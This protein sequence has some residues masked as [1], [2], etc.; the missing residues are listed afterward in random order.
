MPLFLPTHPESPAKKGGTHRSGRRQRRSCRSLSSRP[1]PP[2]RFGSPVRKPLPGGNSET[3][4]C[5]KHPQPAAGD[6]PPASGSPNDGIRENI[7][8][9]PLKNTLTFPS[10]AGAVL[11]TGQTAGGA[12]R[13]R[14]ALRTAPLF[15]ISSRRPQHLPVV[16]TDS[17]A[18][19]RAAPTGRS[20]PTRGTA[21]VKCP[22]FLACPTADSA[23]G[24][25]GTPAKRPAR[26]A[27]PQA[28]HTGFFRCG[29]ATEGARR[30]TGTLFRSGRTR[31][32]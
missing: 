32:A 30:E 24:T 27:F 28:G 20:R 6:G 18:P 26:P 4:S 22:Y 17:E 7:L 23:P 31:R 16:A 9:A 29:N 14:F 19:L 25:V 5:R 13:D 11:P 2:A 3:A 12:V 21:H 15:G 8:A 10:P 1:Q